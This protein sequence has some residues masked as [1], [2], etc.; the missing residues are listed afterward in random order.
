M[1]MDM[2]MDMDMGTGMGTGMRVRMRMGRVRLHW[3]RQQLDT[4]HCEGCGQA[5][6]RERELPRTGAAQTCGSGSSSRRS[7]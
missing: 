7:A 6:P 2:D 5:A 4:A 3:L 1:D